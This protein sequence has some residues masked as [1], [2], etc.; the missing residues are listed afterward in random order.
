MKRLLSM[1]A[2]AI[3]AMCA[4]A[5]AQEPVF[6]IDGAISSLEMVK[7][8]AQDIISIEVVNDSETLRSYEQGMK[9]IP[10]SL[11]SVVVIT[12]KAYE[13]QDDEWL[14]VEEMPTFMGGN[15]STFRD[16]VMQNIRYPEEATNKGIE[17]DVVVNF[18][19]GKD[20]Y[21]KE[22]RITVLS[23]PDKLLSDEVIRVLKSSPQ[24]TPGKQK[25]QPVV[26]Q[27][28]LP[29]GFKVVKDVEVVTFQ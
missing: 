2:F 1:F 6:I 10:N 28:T 26:V 11:T 12:T 27:F 23:T 25:G 7:Q 3:M 8:S 24:W 15:L 4:T 9:M 14:A 13:G 5:S 29:V 19:V 20:G 22:S 21:I 16:W 17:G 18:C